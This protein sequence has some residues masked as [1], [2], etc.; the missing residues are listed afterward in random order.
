[1]NESKAPPSDSVSVTS[2][3]VVGS[4]TQCLDFDW[5]GVALGDEETILTAINQLCGRFQRIV[6]ATTTFSQFHRFVSVIS[7][8]TQQ[9]I[10]IGCELALKTWRCVAN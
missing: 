10:S 6:D 7:T 5:P 8:L 9:R 3:N 4:T 1:M 2:L